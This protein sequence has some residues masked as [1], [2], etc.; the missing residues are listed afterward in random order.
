M[1]KFRTFIQNNKMSYYLYKNYFYAFLA[2]IMVFLN[3]YTRNEYA[4]YYLTSCF[5]FISLQYY[6]IYKMYCYNKKQKKE[7]NKELSNKKQ[8]LYGHIQCP[9]FFEY[10]TVYYCG[11]FLTNIIMKGELYDRKIIFS[12]I[13]MF[14]LLIVDS[15]LWDVMLLD[16]INIEDILTSIIPSVVVILYIIVRIMSIIDG[17]RRDKSEKLKDDMNRYNIQYTNYYIKIKKVY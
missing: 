13:T 7:C 15:V 12:D 9:H 3:M 1:K 14:I 8:I 16:G 11:H 6:T 5:I 4:I 17:I 2:I 10:I